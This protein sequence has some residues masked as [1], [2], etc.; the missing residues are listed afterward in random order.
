MKRKNNAVY[1][2]L[3]NIPANLDV[4]NLFDELTLKHNAEDDEENIFVTKM[5][6]GN[7]SAIKKLERKLAEYNF[8]IRDTPPI[9]SAYKNRADLIISLEALE[10]IITNTPSIDRYVFITS[11]SDFTVIMEML[12][13]YG[14]EVYLVTKESVASKPIFN[15]CCDEILL[16][17][18][19]LTGV[20]EKNT[21][22]RNAGKVE[23]KK[24]EPK[25]P[26]NDAIVY[27]IMEKILETI[28]PDAWQYV[29]LIGSRCHQMDKSRIIGRSSYKTWGNLLGE[30]EK[31]RIIERRKGDKGHPEIRKLT[32]G[33]SVS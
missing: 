23:A 31:K 18:D 29:S 5:A 13:K 20:Q 15:N 3:E 12:R 10:T 1:I 16:L 7:S 6:C 25:G 33:V 24:D 14:K 4:K 21:G 27:G 8:I 28:E 32:G 19:F 26:T 2:D 9:T 30:F 11:D 17:E 22:G